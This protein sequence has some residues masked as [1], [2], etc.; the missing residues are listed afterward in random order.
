MD[1]SALI[2]AAVLRVHV[3]V[4]VCVAQALGRSSA[5]RFTLVVFDHTS[6]HLVQHPLHPL[7]QQIVGAILCFHLVLCNMSLRPASYADLAPAAKVLAAAFKD[8][9]CFGQFMHPYRE[10]YPDGMYLNFLRMLRKDYYHGPD[11]HVIVTYSSGVDGKEDRV[12]GVAHW[13]RRRAG[14]PKPSLYNQAI[15]KSVEAYN[16]LETFVYPDRA[17][18]PTR[19]DVLEKMDPFIEHHWTG[20][21]AEGWYLSL[22]GVDPTAE[23]KGYGRALV[24]YGLD[25]AKRDGVVCSVIAGEG[26]DNFYRACG[27]DVFLGNVTDETGDQNPL[28]GVAGGNIFFWDNGI[29][30]D[31]I[32]KY[33]EV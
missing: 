9:S 3:L 4:D 13:Y 21:R 26:R 31:G 33:G 22:I 32:K 18:D 2:A 16:Y 29:K 6:P 1:T 11:H 24:K 25:L 8:E 7:R 28:V 20:T 23:K 19:L 27:F 14:S 30:P 15:L 10:Q 17:A 5:L 12:T